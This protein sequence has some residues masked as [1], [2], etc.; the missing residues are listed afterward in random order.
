MK[1]VVLGNSGTAVSA[2]C[3]GTMH[4]GSRLEEKG[5]F[6]IMDAYYEHGGRFLDTANNYV[7]WL[8]GCTGDE[9]ELTVGKWI[10]ERNNRDKIFLATKCGVRPA[11]KN[12]DGSFAF[13]VL[14]ARLLLPT[15]N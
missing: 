7:F 10:R 11:G 6:E 2:M 15:S 4:F 14:A 13:K 5:S 9:S 1:K 3:L 12:P 8:D